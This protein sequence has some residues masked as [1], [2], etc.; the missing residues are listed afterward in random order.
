HNDAITIQKF[1]RKLLRGDKE[2]DK[3]VNGSTNLEKIEHNGEI[4]HVG[5]FVHIFN[6]VDPG[7][8]NIAHIQKIWENKE[9]DKFSHVCWYY[10]PEQTKHQATHKF[11]ENE[12]F[13]TS[14][15]L[16]I[17][18]NDV[19]EKCYVL[20]HKDYI[21]GRPEGSDGMSVYLCKS[22]YSEQQ[23][24]F[25]KIKKWPGKKI[26]LVRYDK[27]LVLKKVESALAANFR[28]SKD[29]NKEMTKEKNKEKPREKLKDKPKDKHKDKPRDKT[30]EKQ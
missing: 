15:F 21:A 9:G 24:N 19:V 17:S 23:T 7:L 27:P 28:K 13:K 18:F 5:D 11:Y 10:R 6:E 30:R 25:I 12:V 29:K 16:D 14:G 4:Y 1:A 3:S 22:R 20:Q 26:N 2:Q 8:P